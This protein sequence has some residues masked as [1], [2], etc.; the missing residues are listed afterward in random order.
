MNL[1]PKSERLCSRKQIEA[2][3]TSGQSFFIYPFKVYYEVQGT[4]YKVQGIENGENL[5]PFTFHP[6][7]FTLLISVPKR[8][9]KKAVQRN[10]MKRRTRE[11]WRTHKPAVHG[12]E[13]I[14]QY[15]ANEPLS[16]K[17]I[18]ESVVQ[19]AQQLEQTIC[20]IKK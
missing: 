18:E 10:L 5:V 11:A 20:A 19:I 14:L 4:R 3:F 1:F 6:S 16:Y 9:I 13:I 2:L 7:P 17:K 12:A 8:R 15:V